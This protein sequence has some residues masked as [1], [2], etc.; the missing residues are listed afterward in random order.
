MSTPIQNRY[1][2]VYF[3]DVT[4]GNPRRTVRFRGSASIS[5]RRPC[6]TRF[7]NKHI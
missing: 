6:S 1:D 5:A 7:T 2:F 3:F 4:D